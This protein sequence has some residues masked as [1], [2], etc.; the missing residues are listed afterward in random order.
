MGHN[1]K[2]NYRELPDLNFWDRHWTVKNGVK[3]GY[4]KEKG[5]ALR[6]DGESSK[7]ADLIG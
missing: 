1:S 4:K 2:R 5:K 6:K 3:A 7:T